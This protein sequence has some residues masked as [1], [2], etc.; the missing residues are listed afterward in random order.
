MGTRNANLLDGR[1]KMVKVECAKC[2]G[3][4][5]IREFSH[6]AGGTC[7]D[8]AGNGYFMRK[9][10]PK[11]SKR[12]AVGA[13]HRESGEVVFPIFY[14]NAKT[15]SAALKAAKNTLSGGIGYHHET[16]FVKEV[17]A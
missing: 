4:G 15:E 7:F 1:E 10:A 5:T 17:N 14:K 6:V 11:P 12:W 3:N 9:S 16:A 13:T 8:C 2:G